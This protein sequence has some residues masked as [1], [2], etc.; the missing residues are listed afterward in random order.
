MPR[1]NTTSYLG[2]PKLKTEG[3]QQQF[4]LQQ[5][6][7]YQ[8]CSDDPIYFIKNY[9]KIVNVDRGEIPF[10]LYDFQEQMILKFVHNRFNIVKPLSIDTP[11]PTTRG[12]IALDDVRV[13]DY[14]YTPE[15][16]PTR[17]NGVTESHRSENCYKIT[18]DSGESIIAD[19]DHLW[20]VQYHQWKSSRELTT[21]KI[22]DWHSTHK[23]HKSNPRLRIPIAEAVDGPEIDLPIDPYLFGYWLGD[24]DS[25]TGRITVDKKD[26]T[27][28]TENISEC[29]LAPHST[30][31]NVYRVRV[32]GLSVKL[33]E[34]GVRSNKHI[35]EIYF[36][37]S[38][39]QRLG[40]LQGLMD[41]DGTLSSEG[42]SFSQ[43]NKRFIVQVQRLIRSLGIKCYITEVPQTASWRL[44]F[45]TGLPVFR[46]PRKLEKQQRTVG[47]PYHYISD[48]QSA[49]GCE[50][51][52]LHIDTTDHLFLCGESHISTHN[53]PRQVGKSITTCAFL[54]WTILFNVQQNIAILANKYKTAQKLLSDLKK[55]YMGIPKW[56]QQ[57]VIEWNKTNIELENGCKIMSS[58]TASDAIRGNAFNLIFLDEFAFVPAHIADDFFKSVYPTISSGETSKVI[59]VSTP[60]GMNMFHAMWT[61]ANN[62]HNSPDPQIK[63]NGYE[64]FAIHWSMVPNPDGSGRRDEAWK[65]KTIAL[66]S[67]SQFRQ[68]FECEFIG[69]SNT[70]IDHNKLEYLM[71]TWKSPYVS[72]PLKFTDEKLDVQVPPISG[73]QYVLT[74][75]VAG[76]KELDAS[77]FVIFDITTMPYQAVAKYQS[78][79]IT[80]MLFPDVISQAATKY[81]NAYVMVET[82][83]ND[84]AKSLQMEL[85]YENIITT[86][87]RGKGTQVGG[88]FTKNV[89]FGLRSNKGTKRI[90]C[91]NLKTLIESDKLLVH[92]YQIINELT[93]FISVRN[94]YA[95]EEGK[96][97]DLAMCLVNFGWLVNQK[98]FKEL[99]DTD[100]YN[101]LKKDYERAL[102]EDVSF[103]GIISSAFDDGPGGDWGPN[104]PK[105]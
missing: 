19:G 32:E 86:T 31:P 7:E 93:S 103:F 73:H 22:F 30:C 74:A 94:S 13:G 96:H 60:N 46:L 40:L 99:T 95:A 10:Q 52:C 79:K 55:S 89:E 48:I 9:V 104:P 70:L 36:R 4:T 24:G 20:D 68:E 77:A 82:N 27:S 51:K 8:K 41:S 92:D 21:Q 43:S 91:G 65:K 76:G 90:G 80:P 102:E 54:L 5:L 85:E 23:N 45:V 58:S 66:T 72:V 18:F 100:V 35:P 53:C 56:M 59:I 26:A 62:P 97:D 14:V 15:G 38:F 1:S 37:A 25:D 78:D 84:V 29:R 28:L 34:I 101:Q 69:S 57:G 33:A 105:L 11:I 42:N 39:K 64:P 12:L 50:V 75:D 2:N 98:Y 88:G 87:T 49:E 6:S 16:A 81:N 67:E 17:V 47:L 63:W 83:D 44:Y 71:K 61:Q 3:V